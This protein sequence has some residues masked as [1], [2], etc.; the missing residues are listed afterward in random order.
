[1]WLFDAWRVLT[2]LGDYGVG[3]NTIIVNKIFS[4]VED[5]YL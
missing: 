3:I 1:M 4:F 5:K 2:H